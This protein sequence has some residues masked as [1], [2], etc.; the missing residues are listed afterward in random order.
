VANDVQWNGDAAS[1]EIRRLAVGFLL[2]AALTVKRRAQELLSV[3]GTA[4]SIGGKGN[5]HKKGTRIE[6]A[7]RSAPGEPPRKQSGRLRG[8]PTA[9]PG[10]TGPEDGVAY[11]IDAANLAARVGTNVP[12][13]KYLEL[14]TKRGIAPRPWLRRALAEMQTQVNQLLSQIGKT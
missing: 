1:A 6:G 12:Y 13:G 14:G 5:K 7:I 9:A 10:G 2:R 4:V 11:E 3:P 8:S